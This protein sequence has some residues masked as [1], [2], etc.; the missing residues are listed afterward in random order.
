M[1]IVVAVQADVTVAAPAAV[2]D[3]AV[4]VAVAGRGGP[5]DP[6]AQA[7]L[8][9][10]DREASSATIVRGAT[11]TAAKL[12]G[13]RHAP[14]PAGCFLARRTMAASMPKMPT[15]PAAIVARR[16]IVAHLEIAAHLEIVAHRGIHAST[17]VVHA[18]PWA[19][20]ESVRRMARARK[21]RRAVRGRREARA[22][23][24]GRLSD[25]VRQM[26]VRGQG[27]AILATA[28]AG[29]LHGGPTAATVA[30]MAMLVEGVMIA[31][32]PDVGVAAGM[33]QPCLK[34]RTSRL[35]PLR[36]SLRRYHR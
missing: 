5:A 11:A 10:Q 3:L 27:R 35:P 16:V 1:A 26:A 31:I 32:G 29:S 34:S 2:E 6:A 14:V 8:V 28:D 25:R 23:E 21:M 36:T 13:K 12:A 15:R 4:H 18:H 17:T 19:R 7:D 33:S 22:G 20:Q 30:P 9:D 24:T